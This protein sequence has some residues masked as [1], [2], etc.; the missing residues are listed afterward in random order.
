MNV[1]KT[2]GLFVLLAL[3]PF[4]AHASLVTRQ[5]LSTTVSYF[6]FGLMTVLVVYGL[7]HYYFTLH[8][9][10]VPQ[11]RLFEGTQVALWPRLTV[12]IAAHNEEAVIAKCIEALIAA[13][14]PR[15]RYE[16]IPVND[17]SSD[18]TKA[19]CD[20]WAAKYPHLVK[21]F[22]R[23]TGKAGKPAALKDAELLANGEVLVVFDAD[24]IPS[25]GL[26]KQIV[27]PFLDP[28]IGVTMGRVVPYN[29]RVN[30]LTRSLDM[31][32]S[33]GY[34]VDQQARQDLNL[35]P[36]FGG[37]V[38]GIRRSAL[39]A[40]GGFTAG[41]LSEDTD[42]TFR[43]LSSGWKVGYVNSAECYEEVP[44]SWP[45][46]VKQLMRWA[47]GHNQAMFRFTRRSVV[48]PYFSTAQK[49]ESCLVLGVYA[50]APL[51]VIGWLLV[52]A[53]YFLGAGT[54]TALALPL[55]ALVAYGGFGNAAAFFE[56]AAAVRLDGNTRRLRIL[57][58]IAIGYSVSALT[59]SR[60]CLGLIADT[61]LKRELKW[62]KT[63]RFRTADMVIPSSTTKAEE[64]A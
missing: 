41:V 58:L 37:T 48:N 56:M 64:H 42:L 57:P 52:M 22:H 3:L 32:R 38:G 45:V 53:S 47:K 15:D 36:Q 34:Q 62:D 24:Y 7:R 28:E 27:S 31:E 25:V 61:L 20:E 43:L 14:Y 19:I 11:A 30:L 9:L 44:E 23:E 12:F 1:L 10:F 51:T 17:R 6:L 5:Q 4:S 13:D 63:A 18:G 60:G 50:V 46:R 39:H 54:A 49:I 16:I 21:P 8:R 33:A 40:V 35:L 59:I 26:L 29:V 55:L 2:R